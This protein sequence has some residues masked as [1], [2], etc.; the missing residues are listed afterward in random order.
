MCRKFWLR[1]YEIK[2]KNCYFDGNLSRFSTI[3]LKQGAIVLA[4][5]MFFELVAFY[6]TD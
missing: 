1:A 4:A 2:A 5:L 6:W 3:V